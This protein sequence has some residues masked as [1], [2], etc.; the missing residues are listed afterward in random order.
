MTTTSMI[1]GN[2]RR[3][4]LIE[5]LQKSNGKAELRDIVEFIAEEEG[6]TD[7][8]HRKSVYV[9]LVQTHIPKMERA[10]I[11]SFERGIVE[12]IAVPED[13]DIY[14]EVVEKHDISWS[15]FYA[16]VS[17]IFA[18]TGLWLSNIPLTIAAGIYLLLSMIH[19]M[20]VYRVIRSI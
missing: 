16:G 14:M 20:K 13:V 12:L 17:L 1:L 18:L 7:R 11:I 5:Y 19:R 4:L 6:Q 9:S 8:R 10:G 2:E 15:T 3:M